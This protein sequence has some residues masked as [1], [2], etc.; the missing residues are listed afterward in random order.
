MFD[1]AV[2]KQRAVRGARQRMAE[3][4]ARRAAEAAE[5]DGAEAMEADSSEAMTADSTEADS[6]EAVEA[7]STEAESRGT[8]DF[9]S[10]VVRNAAGSFVRSETPTDGHCLYR[11]TAE[12]MVGDQSGWSQMRWKTA[13]WLKANWDRMSPSY[14]LSKKKVMN[15]VKFGATMHMSKG[16]VK[17]APAWA[18]GGEQELIAVAE[19]MGITVMVHCS[20][21]GNVHSY[22]SGVETKWLY[23]DD[24]RQHYEAMHMVGEDLLQGDSIPAAEVEKHC[25]PWACEKCTYVNAGPEAG[26]LACGACDSEREGSRSG[27]SEATI[28]AGAASAVVC[29][30]MV[31]AEDQM[32][33]AVCAPMIAAEDQMVHV[34]LAYGEK[35]HMSSCCPE[36]DPGSAQIPWSQADSRSM[37]PCEECSSWDSSMQ[38]QHEQQ[39]VLLPSGSGKCFHNNEMCPALQWG[40]KLCTKLEAKSRMKYKCPHCAQQEITPTWRVDAVEPP[41]KETKHSTSEEIRDLRA[42]CMERG[43]PAYGQKADLIKRLQRYDDQRMFECVQCAQQMTDVCMGCKS[44]MTCMMYAGQ[45]WCRG[46]SKC[47]MCCMCRPPAYRSDAFQ[48]PEDGDGAEGERTGSESDSEEP[49]DPEVAADMEEHGLTRDEATELGREMDLV[50]MQQ[51]DGRSGKASNCVMELPAIPEEREVGPY[52]MQTIW[53]VAKSMMRKRKLCVI[54][55]AVF[56]PVMEKTADAGNA[57]SWEHMWHAQQ[58]AAGWWWHQTRVQKYQ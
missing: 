46:C 25:M 18:W 28:V 6:S 15:A 17:V 5:A 9:Q 54:A 13:E 22:G 34:A 40:H 42:W 21:H 33:H 14:T 26:F 31:T 30:P 43:L 44:C 20:R 35:Y 49:L 52:D 50:D 11:S 45:S 3:C 39:L 8:S 36:L 24:V 37:E 16:K 12:V 2:R 53:M 4:A 23:F 32:F 47:T 1:K 10:Q 27:S 57:R 58:Q 41:V 51:S 56:A 38:Q 55:P 48:G 29:A 7:D 19:S